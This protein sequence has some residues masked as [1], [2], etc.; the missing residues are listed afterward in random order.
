M[1]N[2]NTENNVQESENEDDNVKLKIVFILLEVVFV[3]I[4]W[5]SITFLESETKYFGH[6]A[7][8]LAKLSL[9]LATLMFIPALASIFSFIRRFFGWFWTGV[10]IR[11]ILPLYAVIFC[12]TITVTDGW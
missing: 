11:L 4:A 5:Y 10:F 9:G 6:D 3:L 7:G 8:F 12:I 2:Q 1:S